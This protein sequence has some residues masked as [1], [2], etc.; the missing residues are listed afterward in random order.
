MPIKAILKIIQD[1]NKSLLLGYSAHS[2]EEARMVEQAGVDWITFSPIFST[3]S[4][5]NFGA[6]QGIN[7]LKKV[8]ENLSIPVYAL[9]GIKVNNILEVLET[10]VHGLALISEIIA[11]KEPSKATDTIL[12]KL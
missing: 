11:A 5:K 9:G 3:P 7:I 6:P 2:L 8:V 1:S 10:G 4:K 12:S